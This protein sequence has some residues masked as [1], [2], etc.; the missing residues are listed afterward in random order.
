MNATEVLERG[1]LSFSV[2]SRILRELGERLVKQ[3]EVAILELIKN[4]YDA[5]ATDCIVETV[6]G[7]SI[8]VT[9]DGH[10]MTLEQF[11][12]SWM[13]IGTSVKA[14]TSTSPRY[15]RLITGEKRHRPFCGEIP[16]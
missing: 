8:A 2:E 10:G 6:D 13:R 5:D 7:T 14:K 16:W 12:S 1:R 15:N 3:P 11:R 4:T 9:D